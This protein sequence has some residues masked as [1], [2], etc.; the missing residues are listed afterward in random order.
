MRQ[1]QHVDVA[2]RQRRLLSLSGHRSQCGR[3]TP[4]NP[5]THLLLCSLLLLVQEAPFIWALLDRHDLQPVRARN[6]SSGSS[7]SQQQRA[8]RERALSAPRWWPRSTKKTPAWRRRGGTT[9]VLCLCIMVPLL[10]TCSPTWKTAVTLLSSS[11]SN[12]I[13]SSMAAASCGCCSC[14]CAAPLCE[15]WRRGAVVVRR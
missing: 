7:G 15:R 13:E 2:A 10:L 14:S 3:C 12:S 4:L 11:S 6:S 8:A 1:M 5:P 9:Y